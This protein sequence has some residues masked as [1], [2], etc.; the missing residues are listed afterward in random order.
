MLFLEL[1]SEQAVE[2]AL[3]GHPSSST[4]QGRDEQ[5]RKLEDALS[6]MK[7]LLREAQEKG[8]GLRNR[9]SSSRPGSARGDTGSGSA[10]L[11][12]REF[13][14]KCQVAEVERDRLTEYVQVYCCQ[15]L[16]HE[17]IKPR[18]Y[19]PTQPC[20]QPGRAVGT[21]L[22]LS[23]YHICHVLPMKLNSIKEVV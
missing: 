23:S 2:E 21:T 22:C 8:Q 19:N 1:G 14:T 5:I 6:S 4:W 16:G 13:Q 12:V 18:Y 20:R 3:S 10:G 15:D 11:R 7:S 17:I 9:P